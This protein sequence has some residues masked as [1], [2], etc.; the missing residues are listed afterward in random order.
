MQRSTDHRTYDNKEKRTPALWNVPKIKPKSSEILML[1]V[2]FVILQ[3]KC[4]QFRKFKAILVRGDGAG[5][6]DGTVHVLEMV[7]SGRSKIFKIIEPL[8][9]LNINLSILSQLCIL[10]IKMVLYIYLVVAGEDERTMKI[11]VYKF[12][13]LASW[14]SNVIDL[15]ASGLNFFVRLCNN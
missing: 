1:C 8:V 10:L 5:R 2:T 3:W 7:G 14:S 4:A 15:V 9:S 11:W 12:L 6:G 13:R